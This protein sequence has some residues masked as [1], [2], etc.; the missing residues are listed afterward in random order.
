NAGGLLQTEPLVLHHVK[1]YILDS[2]PWSIDNIKYTLR[3]AAWSTL[4]PSRLVIAVI[5][6]TFCLA[7]LFSL[8][9]DQNNTSS[10]LSQG[11]LMVV[12]IVSSVGFTLITCSSYGPL[13][14]SLP[15]TLAHKPYDMPHKT[16][17]QNEDEVRDEVQT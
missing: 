13:A 7:A 9:R 5:G 15:L 17:S 3:N 16:H 1:L 12:L 14:H 6:I 11:T 8:L 2:T 10:A 4:F